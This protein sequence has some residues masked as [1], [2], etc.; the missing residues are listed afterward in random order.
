MLLCSAAAAQT[1][2]DAAVRPRLENVTTVESW[3]FF[4]PQR[5]G[6][7]PTYSAT[8]HVSASKSKGNG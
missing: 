4:A 1:G 5:D 3:S 2:A 7:D 6:A 8:A